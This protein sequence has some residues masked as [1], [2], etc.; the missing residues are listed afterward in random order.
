MLLALCLL[1]ACGLAGA[2][3][4]PSLGKP[5][6]NPNR[7]TAFPECPGP[8]ENYFIWANYDRFVESAKGGGRNALGLQQQ[9][10]DQLADQFLEICRNPEYT[11]AESGILQILYRLVSDTERRK[12]AG[13]ADLMARV[14]RIRAVRTTEELTGLMREEAFLLGN[15]FFSVTLQRSANDPD[16][17]VI[18]INS[19]MMLDYLPMPYD[20]TEEE[21]MNGPQLDRETPR[22]GLL[23]MQYSEE[24]AERIIADVERYGD[25]IGSGKPDWLDGSRVSLRQIRENCPPLCAMLY[26]T[27]FVRE[28]DETVKAYEIDPNCIGAFTDWY[29]EDHLETLKI[30]GTG[31]I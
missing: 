17:A 24:E 29:T 6:I 3:A 27:G 9:I 22:R 23:L 20:P 10:E 4:Q 12:Q 11:D 15:P 19:K 25:S 18:G 16:M 5:W 31:T 8:E 21:M 14:D 26:G 2:E 1:A 28:N 13:L 7:C 30:C